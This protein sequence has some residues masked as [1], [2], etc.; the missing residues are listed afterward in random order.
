MENP[1][2]VQSIYDLQYFNCPSCVFKNQSKQVFVN[3]AFYCHPNS[4]HCLSKI[5][6][7]SF[8]D[9]ICPWNRDDS[10]TED[11]SNSLKV[12]I[13]TENNGESFEAD[14]PDNY[15]D[16][17]FVE[18]N[19]ETYNLEADENGSNLEENY[20]PEPQCEINEIPQKLNLFEC[21]ICEKTF[22]RNQHL[23]R[24]IATGK[25]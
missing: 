12:E 1:W 9:I 20:V 6:D 18:E 23:Q 10:K 3:H 13:K 4:V 21:K 17:N 16:G 8:T 22:T 25:N 7:E 11:E 14:S 19:D 5:K 15:Y 2:D 24:H